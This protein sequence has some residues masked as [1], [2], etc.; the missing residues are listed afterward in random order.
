MSTKRS[1]NRVGKESKLVRYIKGP[2]RI[3]ARARDFYVTSLTGCA[4]QVAYAG[5]TFQPAA[6]P[7]SFST[8]SA[9]DT[10]EL[11]RIASARAKSEAELLRMKKRSRSV[12]IGRIDE[13]APCEFDGAGRPG[14]EWLDRVVNHFG[15]VCRNLKVFKHR[16]SWRTMILREIWSPPTT[17]LGLQ[18]TI[19]SRP[20]IRLL[21]VEPNAIDPDG[22]SFRFS[23]V[24]AWFT[25]DSSISWRTDQ[26]A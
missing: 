19:W 4:D 23:L 12:V 15:V 10:T 25:G 5:A 13:D 9:H 18:A 16:G 26:L 8:S 14:L 11:I 7:R 20:A 24:L 17:R 3:L 2:I 21:K 1:N 6:L 22:P